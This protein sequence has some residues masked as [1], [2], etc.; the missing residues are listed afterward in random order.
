MSRVAFDYP[1]MRLLN[2]HDVSD[3]QILISDHVTIVFF[4]SLK[5]QAVYDKRLNW[6]CLEGKHDEVE[7]IFVGS[8]FISIFN[9]LAAL[10][11]M[12]VENREILLRIT[13]CLSELKVLYAFGVQQPHSLRSHD[14]SFRCTS[15]TRQRSF[16]Q[17]KTLAR[18][19]WLIFVQQHRESGT[20]S[21]GVKNISEILKLNNL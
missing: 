14:T 10:Q 16:C 9:L 19:L 8:N 13:V 4:A 12:L 3:L 17:C 5:L 11:E 7:K 18:L 1:E 15:P 20:I 21:I 6:I 2:G